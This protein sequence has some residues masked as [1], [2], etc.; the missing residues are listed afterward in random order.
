[1]PETFN[2]IISHLYSGQGGVSREVTRY[3]NSTIS[4]INVVDSG[5]TTKYDFGG[6]CNEGLY[7]GI[8][9]WNQLVQ[10]TT[11]HSGQE[12]NVTFTVSNET[13][14]V[15]TTAGGASGYTFRDFNPA[16]SMISG[17]KYLVYGLPNGLSTS[18]CYVYLLGGGVSSNQFA[19]NSIIT[20]T[21]STSTAKFRISV[22]SGTIITTPLVF[23][24]QMFDLTNIYGAG[25]EPSTVMEFAS[26][27]SNEYYPY[28]P[29]T[30][31]STATELFGTIKQPVDSITFYGNT[32]RWCQLVENGNFADTSG[33]NIS[34]G[35]ISVSGNVAEITFTD[36]TAASS[37]SRSSFSRLA[38]HK[39][40]CSCQIKLKNTF[41]QTGATFGFSGI[42][43]TYVN[44]STTEWQTLSYIDT[45]TANRSIFLPPVYKW[46]QTALTGYFIKNFMIIDLTY[47]FGAGNEPT[48]DE[49][50]GRLKK[51]YY[52][53]TSGEIISIEQATAYVYGL[54]LWDE[55]W[56]VG[57]I[58]DT[59]GLDDTTTNKIRSKNYIRVSP[60]ETYYITIPTGVILYFYDENK[61]F[62]GT[63][64]TYA[65]DFT[66]LACSMYMRFRT[67]VPYGTT[68]NN[69]ICINLSDP[70]VNGTYKASQGEQEVRLDS[71]NVWDEEWEVGK[72]NWDGTDMSSSTNIRS[73]N[74][75]RI[76]GGET[77]YVKI[78]DARMEVFYYDANK[79]FISYEI[80][81][82]ANQTITTPTNACYMRFFVQQAYGTTYNHD[83]C[84]N[85]SDSALNGTYVPHRGYVELKG[86]GDAVD[87]VT[88]EKETTEPFGLVDLGDLVWYRDTAQSY[89][90][91]YT[92]SLNG[93]IRSITTQQP[94]ATG[95]Y[96]RQS[97]DASLPDWAFANLPDKTIGYR[98]NGNEAGSR[99]IY[100]KDLYYTDPTAFKNSLKGKYMYFQLDGITYSS[101]D[102]FL[103]GSYVKNI[104]SYTFT[105][106]EQFYSYGTGGYY[107]QSSVLSSAP[108]LGSSNIIS[109]FLAPVAQPVDVRDVQDGI[110]IYTNGNVYMSQPPTNL[111]GV[112]ISYELAT[113]VETTLT[114]QQCAEILNGAFTKSKYSTVLIDNDNGQIDQTVDV[115]VWK[116]R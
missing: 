62:I 37:L 76:F 70:D 16:F 75:I 98:W 104:G 61:S 23:R 54:N 9:I 28:D 44:G 31:F 92:S 71:F 34:N 50:N 73:K 106:Q 58:S 82:V 27:Y 25:N 47:I 41:S 2:P 109:D 20:C 11:T 43:S 110:C 99:Y 38:G 68:Y 3:N 115:G 19:T 42:S 80:S 52:P 108:K 15:S 78:P 107:I 100:I 48:A 63:I 67:Y 33:W 49:F 4:E 57:G 83:I 18:T 36:T 88:V 96:N 103:S 91:F 45:E 56:E 7:S 17:H 101:N 55:E 40:F 72:I 87:T 24:F 46:A 81:S 102:P 77:Y 1:M 59:T 95:A 12:N 69:D 113:P 90:F 116:Q 89:P 30:P 74:Y 53:N 112:T 105:G 29:G 39:Y 79:A 26:K 85:L 65:G 32:M 94:I 86:V 21:S 64:D 10:N 111:V 93:L 114:E 14:S 51:L 5:V 22:E 35:T 97:S 13:V 6:L 60:N 84:I 66:P 8:H